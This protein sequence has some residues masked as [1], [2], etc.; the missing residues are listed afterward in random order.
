MP[1]RTAIRWLLW[2]ACWS[3]CLLASRP[4]HAVAPMCDERGA[5]AI[6]PTPVLPARDVKI[7]AGAPLGCDAP[8]AIVA[9]PGWRAHQHVVVVADGF[10]DAWVRPTVHGLP[11]MTSGSDLAR[12]LLS[13]P[14]SSE[15]GRG[16]FRPP[17]G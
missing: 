2:A 5:S 7:D 17:R 4:A 13:L 8:V 12:S 14:V 6:A 16:V 15:H 9:G 1:S 3:F 11:E 10:E